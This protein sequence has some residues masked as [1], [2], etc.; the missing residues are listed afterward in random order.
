[1]NTAERVI[2]RA[3]EVSECILPQK[4]KIENQYP[5]VFVHG[6]LGWGERDDINALVPYWG[7]AGA[8]I[9]PFLRARGAQCYAASVGPVSSAWDRA[10]ELYAQLTG[11]TVDYGIAHSAEFGHARFG[12][13]YDKPLFDGWSADKKI[14]LIGHSFGGT[15]IRLFL[16]ILADGRPE[17]VAAAKREGTAVSPFFEGGR[18]GWVHSISAIGTPH[19]GTTF[20]EANPNSAAVIQSLFLAYARA[21]GIT[22]FKGVFDFQLDQFGMLKKSDESFAEAVSRVIGS[23]KLPKAD[24]AYGDL[25]VDLALAINNQIALRNNVYYFSY[26]GSKTIISLTSYAHKPCLGMTPALKV[27]SADIGGYY[28]KKTAAGNYISKDWAENDGLVNTISAKYPTRSDGKCLTECGSDGFVLQSSMCCN[29]ARPGV[30]NVMP[31]VNYDH[32]ALIGGLLNTGGLGTKMFYKQI[33]D[34]I[35]AT[36]PDKTRTD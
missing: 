23:G 18:G 24:S 34:N 32:L 7:L 3:F 13:C 22:K 31:V 10:C 8:H 25:S 11:T 15:T 29:N 33:A 4:N 1:M 16:D 26:P 19:N 28:D 36:M 14:N 6:L 5:F 30:W 2:N 21:L 17:E 9:L 12:I 27:F 20:F 35:K